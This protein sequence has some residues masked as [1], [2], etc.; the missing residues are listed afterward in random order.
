MNK[1][2]RKM[3]I[4][5]PT[6]EIKVMITASLRTFN[7]PYPVS[8]IIIDY[9]P[10]ISMMKNALRLL[11]YDSLHPYRYDR[12]CYPCLT[13]INSK[14]N[15]FVKLLK[16][17]EIPYKIYNTPSVSLSNLVRDYESLFSFIKKT[18]VIITNEK[19]ITVT[20]GR[21]RYSSEQIRFISIIEIVYMISRIVKDDVTSYS[22]GIKFAIPDIIKFNTSRKQEVVIPLKIGTGDK[23]NRNND[24]D[25][26][27]LLSTIL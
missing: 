24:E 10:I 20:L 1:K 22:K 7:I 3:Q 2:G 5:W 27:S 19:K 6:Q 8:G 23:I 12:L 14:D 13:D 11:E 4:V 21:K 26:Y 16:K 25:S 9:L 17:M 18:N 15:R